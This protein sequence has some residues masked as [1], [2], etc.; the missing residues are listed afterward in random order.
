M[1]LPKLLQSLTS[2]HTF[3]VEENQNNS[4]S[5]DNEPAEEEENSDDELAEQTEQLHINECI[6]ETEIPKE[7]TP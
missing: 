4:D 2:V 7:L 1:G 3:D 5:S 6:R